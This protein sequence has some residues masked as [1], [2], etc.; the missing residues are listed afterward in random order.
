L[1]STSAA[2]EY[3]DFSAYPETNEWFKK[4]KK[5]IPNYEKAAGGGAD[6]F[7]GFFKSKKAENKL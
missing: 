2:S 6:F 7:G 3:F 1:Y 4:I 5:E